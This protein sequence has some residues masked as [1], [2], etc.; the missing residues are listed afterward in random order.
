MKRRSE[1]VKGTND[2]KI[3]ASKANVFD[4]VLEAE[5]A[6]SALDGFRI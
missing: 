3:F 2:K 4:V 6:Y 5:R 1:L